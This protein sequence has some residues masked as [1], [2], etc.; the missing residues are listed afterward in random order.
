M[1]GHLD[2]NGPHSSVHLL[3]QFSIERLV[4][5]V[6]PRK[7]LLDRKLK[8]SQSKQGFLE[9][10]LPSNHSHPQSFPAIIHLFQLTLN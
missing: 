10:L 9:F 1:L 3:L 5:V 4:R 2:F 7:E 6:D 8:L